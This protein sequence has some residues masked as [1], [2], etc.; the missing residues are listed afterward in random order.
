MCCMN[1]SYN[2][3]K[4][5]Y[6]PSPTARKY[7]FNPG[8]FLGG[9]QKRFWCSEAPKIIGSP[10]LLLSVELKT[11]RINALKHNIKNSI[12]DN[13]HRDPGLL[14]L[15]NKPVSY[16]PSSNGYTEDATMDNIKVNENGGWYQH[17]KPYPWA[18]KWMW[19]WPT[20]HWRRRI[21]RSYQLLR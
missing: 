2:W 3:N 1:A 4:L 14:Y 12:G 21:Q 18:K 20:K 9:H 7:F 13:E 17:G 10:F 16:A 6:G 19:Y 11:T 8:F 5:Y 15:N